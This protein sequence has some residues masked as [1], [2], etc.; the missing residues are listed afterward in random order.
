MPR[1]GTRAEALKVDLLDILRVVRKR[2][3]VA[4]LAAVGGF[5]LQLLSFFAR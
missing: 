5:V 2:W 4:G 3:K 1:P